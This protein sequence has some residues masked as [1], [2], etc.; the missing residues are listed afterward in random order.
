MATLLPGLEHGGDAR[1]C[2]EI[3]SIS[4]RPTCWLSTKVAG[5]GTSM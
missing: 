1:D 3:A 4:E 5:T 2:C